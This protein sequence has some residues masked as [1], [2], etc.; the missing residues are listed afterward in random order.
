ML[1]YYFVPFIVSNRYLLFWVSNGHNSV[2]VQNRTHVYMNFFHHKDLGNHL[3]QLCPK[4]VKHPVYIC[5]Y[6]NVTWYWRAGRSKKEDQFPLPPH[7][8]KCIS[9]WT[10]FVAQW[11][12]IPRICFE[13]NFCDLFTVKSSRYMAFGAEFERN[14]INSQKHR[15]S[16]PRKTNRPTGLKNFVTRISCVWPN[17]T[18]LKELNRRGK[19]FLLVAQFDAEVPLKQVSRYCESKLVREFE[20]AWNFVKCL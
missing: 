3:L 18:E 10:T 5:M 11:Y 7:L 20:Q 16:V 17:S 4:V 8:H 9:V 15:G 6:V 19:L 12:K 13:S 14:L 2:T 1:V